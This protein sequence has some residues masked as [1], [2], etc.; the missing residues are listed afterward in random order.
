MLTNRPYVFLLLLCFAAGSLRA[1]R[2]PVRQYTTAD[3]LARNS[4]HRIIRD[5][6]GFLWFA[7]GEGIS[8]FDGYSF[9]NYRRTDGLPDRDIRS[10]VQ[11]AD[12]SFLVATGDGAVRFRPAEPAPSRRFQVFALPGGVRVRSVEAV[13]ERGSTVWI[14]TDDGLY[15]ADRAAQ[16]RAVPEPLNPGGIEPGI[17]TMVCDPAQDLWI[18]TSKGLF[19]IDASG[20]TQRIALAGSPAPFVEALLIDTDGVWVGTGTGALCKADFRKPG[21]PSRIECSDGLQTGLKKSA[22]ESLLHARDGSLWI[23]TNSGL[24]RQMP[25]SPA[26]Q[27]LGESEGFLNG[28]VLA[29]AEDGDGDVWAGY[30]G[31]GVLR[32]SATG[33]VTYD[34]RDGLPASQ[35]AALAMT[36]GG[37]LVVTTSARPGLSAYRLEKDRFQR[38]ELGDDSVFPAGWLPWHQVLA[39]DSHGSWWTGSKHGLLRFLAPNH[40]GGPAR[41]RSVLT[42]ADGVPADDVAHVLEDS[43]GNIWFSILPIVAYPA[44]GFRTGLG[45]WDR[46]TGRIRS[47]SESDGLPPMNSFSILQIAEDHTGQIWIGL[48]RTGVARLRQGRFQ[49]FTTADGIPSGGIRFIY[50]DREHRLWLG[51][52][53]GGLGCIADPSAATPAIS[54]YTM[55]DGLSSDEIQAITEDN[56]GRIYV[57]T[58]LGVDRFDPATRGIVHYTAADGLAPGEVQ[59]AVRD[60]SGDLWF[61]TYQAVSRL[62]PRPDSP[63]RPLP[64]KVSS[65]RVNGKAQPVDFTAGQ[66]HIADVPPGSNSIQLD[67]FALALSG[68]ENVRYQYRLA[69]TDK[70]WSEPNLLRTTLY[71]NLRPGSYTFQV[72]CL[73]PLPGNPATVRFTVLPHIWERWWFVSLAAMALLGGLYA[74]HS[75]RLAN[76]LAMQAMRTRLARDLHDDIGSGLSK[77]VILSEVAR[78]GN[79]GG[80]LPEALDHIADSSREVL[81]AV[82]DLVW[83]TNSTAARIEDLIPRMRSFASQLF[84]AQGVEFEL[85]VSGTPSGKPLSPEALR[86]LYLIFKEAV[87]NAAKHSRCTRASA[88]LRFEHGRLTMLVAD[89]GTGFTPHAEPGHHGLASLEARSQTLGGKITWHFESGTTVALSIPCSNK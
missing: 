55:A 63:T 84:E 47:F 51:S 23:G 8:R 72:R 69:G 59:D 61:G 81:D 62:H 38:Y 21:T 22:I 32:V 16:S 86:Q 52:G 46:A 37:D 10:I 25:G 87:N 54:R 24:A 5:R 26:V 42:T 27:W 85:R 60:S 3:G 14:G 40:S 82:G 19:V 50:E 68:T 31:T 7:T 65:V 88:E 15:T 18:G 34:E 71:G 83:A 6:D 74:A 9:T 48:Y 43:R 79:G 36:P 1:A 45:M 20:H 12:G 80:A 28:K 58:G 11:T 41:L 30:D 75:Y 44:P 67:Y 39:A 17:L 53:R 73:N 76:I 77:I 66:I 35:V 70:N 78:R 49:V 4:I 89:N 56:F 33:F 13:I 2:L 29:L 57:G 64:A